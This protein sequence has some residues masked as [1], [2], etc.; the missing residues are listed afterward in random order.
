MME[1]CRGG[2]I[3]ECPQCK[4]RLK[5]GDEKI[6]PEG[7]RFKCPKCNTTFLVKRPESI[8]PLTNGEEHGNAMEASSSKNNEKTDIG[9]QSTASENM[10]TISEG[11]SGQELY[12]GG[13]ETQEHNGEKVCEPSEVKEIAEQP[14]REALLSRLAGALQAKSGADHRAGNRRELESKEKF[15]KWGWFGVLFIV[16]GIVQ[17]ILEGGTGGTSATLSFGIVVSTSA[18]LA[19]K[20]WFKSMSGFKKA[21]IICLLIF[22]CSVV[23]DAILGVK[24]RSDTDRAWTDYMQRKELKKQWGF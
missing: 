4:T 12:K 1:H 13:Q 6:K 11:N 17:G 8:P 2:M 19:T 9:I 15:K 24:P 21:V 16:L 18:I 20:P 5:I 3:K 7:T 23:M 14:S 22:M 10:I